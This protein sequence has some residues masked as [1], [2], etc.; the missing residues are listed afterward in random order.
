VTAAPLLTLKLA[1]EI[2]IDV[3]VMFVVPELVSTTDSV[4]DLPVVTF[5]KLTVLELG[6]RAD[7]V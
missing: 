4:A 7:A 2:A 6:E 5:P 3:I 1:P